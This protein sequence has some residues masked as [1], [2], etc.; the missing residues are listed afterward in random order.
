[1][2]VDRIGELLLVPEPTD[3]DLAPAFD[4]QFGN[5]G[6][7]TTRILGILVAIQDHHV[8]VDVLCQNQFS[9]IKWAVL[10]S[11]GAIDMTPVD[12]GRET[13]GF[14]APFSEMST[15]VRWPDRLMV[16]CR[17]GLNRNP[18]LLIRCIR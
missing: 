18:K 15:H 17:H 6:R 2:P 14:A 5:K 10:P 8:L 9:S 16:W 11:P 1:M 7:Q 4:D 13:M 12:D 3:Q